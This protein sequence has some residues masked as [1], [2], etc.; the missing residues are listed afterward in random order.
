VP[1]LWDPK[2]LGPTSCQAQEARLVGIIPHKPLSVQ[3]G[4][5]LAFSTS[6]LLERIQ[7]E[8]ARTRS[9]KKESPRQLE[10]L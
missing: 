8:K 3:T 2:A 10:L 4:A 5:A 7:A 9:R 6:A 1:A